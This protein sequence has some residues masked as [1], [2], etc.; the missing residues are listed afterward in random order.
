VTDSLVDLLLLVIR[1][2]GAKAE[3]HIKKQ[4]L[5]EIQTVEG[6]QRLLRHVAEAALAGPEKTI[7]AGIYP[8]MSEEKCKALLKEYQAKGEYHEQV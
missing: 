6:K 5:D 7:R 4:Y 1:R 2:I 8:V 3:K